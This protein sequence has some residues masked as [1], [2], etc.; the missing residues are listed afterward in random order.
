MNERAYYLGKM[1]KRRGYKDERVSL[2]DDDCRNSYER[3]F[4][5]GE[6]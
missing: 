4:N 2:L 1:H 3:G 6:D 5:D